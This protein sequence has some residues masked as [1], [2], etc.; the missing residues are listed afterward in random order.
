MGSLFKE[1]LN[2]YLRDM[3]KEDILN[4]IETKYPV[5]QIRVNGELFWPFFRS[6]LNTELQS[7][8]IRVHQQTPWSGMRKVRNAFLGILNWFSKHDYILFSNEL[9]RKEVDGKFMDKLNEKAMELLGYERCLFVEQVEKE[10]LRKKYYH[11]KVAVS[12]DFV[13]VLS[14]VIVVFQ[15][16]L[17]RMPIEG[18]EVL[19][20][21]LSDHNLVIDYRLKLSLFLAKSIALKYTFR[22]VSPKAVFISD[23][24][25]FYIT[26][27]AK[28]LGIPVVEFQHGILNHA[29]YNPT[30]ELNPLFTPDYLLVFG[31]MD[32]KVLAHGFYV[33]QENI[34][35]IGGLYLELMERRQ[36]QSEILHLLAGFEKSVCVPT[37]V[38]SHDYLVSYIKAVA[39]ALPNVIF[40]VVPRGEFPESRDL[41]SNIHIESR[42]SFQEVVRHCTYNCCTFSTCSLEALSLGTQNVLID[43]DGMT[44]YYF[45][46][47]LSDSRYTLFT[48]SKKELIEGIANFEVKPR[49]EIKASNH[50]AYYPGYSDNLRNALERITS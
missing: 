15:R 2:C 9:E 12:L 17:C 32:K 6:L 20:K 3:N 1:C 26:Y 10:H 24:G 27:A 43:E 22:K 48:K 25:H 35:P 11:P 29:F 23:Y 18:E 31:S 14:F 33:K 21:I 41:P 49:N 38:I 36:Q 16:S 45:G 8:I 50:L 40:I 28:S 42:Y 34:I 39:E 19:K 44:S 5:E 30:K 4:H 47:T 37:S 7:S 46:D 13:L